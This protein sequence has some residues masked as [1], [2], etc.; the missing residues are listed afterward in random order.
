M[1][2]HL[3]FLFALIAGTLL[4]WSSLYVPAPVESNAAGFSAVRAYAD[5]EA[6]ARSP[7]STWDQASLANVRNYLCRRLS[8]LGLKPDIQSY[9]EVTD[10]R[11]YRYPLVNISASIPG[12]SGSSILLVSHYDSAHPPPAN[13]G[14]SCGAADDGYG[15]AAMLEIAGLIAKA[16]APMEN[17]VRFL[18]TDAEES[19][20]L[21]AKAEMSRNLA[22]YRDVNMVINLEARGIKGPAVMFETGTNNFAVIQ[23]FREAHWPFAFSLAADVYRKMPNGTDFSE[24]IGKGFNGLNFA[25][26]E[27]LSYYH[28][29]A[30]NPQN[31]SLRSLQHYGEQILPVVLTYTQNSRYS[32]EHAFTSSQNMV[33]FTWLPKVFL[34]WSSTQD[35]ILCIGLILAFCV[36]SAMGVARG[37]V[38]PKAFILWF[39]GWAG[40]AVASLGIGLGISM[41]LSK[42]S[43]IRWRITYTPNLPLERPLFWALLLA[44]ALIAYALATRFGKK[45][46]GNR[47]A[48]GGAMCL[49]LAMMLVMMS[50]LPGG[51]YLFSLPV[52]VSLAA[53]LLA[54]LTKRPAFALAGVVFTV[55]VFIPLLYMFFLA[56]TMG[57]LGVILLLAVFPFALAGSLAG[58]SK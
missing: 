58:Q 42:A 20:L 11:G 2:R 19:G 56:L 36:W 39:L 50:L 54:D 13:R 6:I 55:S 22:A 51:T 12:K 24:F 33:Y 45:H 18:F 21:G 23:L 30:D 25:V 1:K 44:L 32:G 27:D 37:T 8:S 31:I 40:V 47:S 28:T 48:L 34:A 57:A 16:K 35:R 43:G 3:R 38:K 7:H 9:P 10:R 53:L 26:L 14:N 5:I 15:V 4:G 49:N 46:P 29:S 52:L 41:L 17:G